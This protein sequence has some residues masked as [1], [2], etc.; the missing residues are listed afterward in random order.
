MRMRQT[1]ADFE[2]AFH[3]ET[4]EEQARRARL[5]RQAA[6][7]SRS[8]RVEKVHKSGNLR[9]AGLVLALL[10]TTIIVIVV[11]FQALALLMSP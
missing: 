9:F 1:L 4:A 3:E 10:A 7:R 6:E 8:R 2:A 5:R 11:M